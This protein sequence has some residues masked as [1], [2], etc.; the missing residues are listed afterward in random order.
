MGKWTYKLERFKWEIHDIFHVSLLKQ[1]KTR[2]EQVNKFLELKFD[3]GKDKEYDI[4]AI[5]DN[6]VYN[7]A[8]ED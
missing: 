8:V 5:W 3:V 6:I 7:K 4:V 2:K 1:N